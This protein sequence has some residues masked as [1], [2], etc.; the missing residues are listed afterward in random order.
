MTTRPVEPDEFSAMG[1]LPV[2]S[3]PGFDRS[4]GKHTVRDLTWAEFDAQVQA[5]ARQA[6]GTFKPD[7]VVG[8][9][10]GGV[11]V[12]GALASALKLDFFPVRVTRR[13]RDTGSLAT[14]DMPAELKGRRV[15]IVDDIASSGDSL[16][17][18]LKLARAVGVKH[19]ATLALL[20]RPGG[21][22]PDFTGFTTADFFIFPWDYAPL[23]GDGRFDPEAKQSSVTVSAK[24]KE[25]SR[26]V[27]AKAKQRA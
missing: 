1:G 7:A 8:L 19:L 24:R 20:S 13:S 17:F 3:V 26:G 4:S 16:E 9:V 6:L 14:D 18:A 15:L 27:K 21:Y 5:L 25:R 12:G 11:F 10:H 23:V 2:I 22:E